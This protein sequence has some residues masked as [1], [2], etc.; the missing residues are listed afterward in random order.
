MNI[1]NIIW[2]HKMME[3][4]IELDKQRNMTVEEFCLSLVQRS[5][6]EL[7]VHIA[8]TLTQFIN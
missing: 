5:R 6:H 1:I 8:V 4:K 7:H 2:D 3:P